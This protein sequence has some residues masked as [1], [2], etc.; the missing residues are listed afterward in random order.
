MFEV[1]RIAECTKEYVEQRKVGVIAT[2][3]SS[4]VVVGMTFRTLNN[5][6]EPARRFDIGMLEYAEEVSHE[7]H[8]GNRLGSEPCNKTKTHT[9]QRDPPE[10]VKRT[11]IKGT[12]RVQT[13]GAMMHLVKRLPQEVATVQGVVPHKN[14]ELI[15]EHGK[16]SSPYSSQ[17]CQ[18][19]EPIRFKQRIN[20]NGQVGRQKKEASKGK[21]SPDPPRFYFW[22]FSSRVNGFPQHKH[23]VYRQNDQGN[24]V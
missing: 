12:V 22:Q 9:A 21:K 18:I 4:S 11:E 6:P 2:M 20:E 13:L 15:Q 10:H 7:D 14:P 17:I 19:E 8:D 16:Y 24:R 3:N 5:V 23:S 1:L